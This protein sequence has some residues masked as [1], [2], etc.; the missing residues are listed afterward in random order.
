MALHPV[1]V[2]QLRQHLILPRS[3]DSLRRR[4][5]RGRIPWRL[6]PLRRYNKG[7]AEAAT[8]ERG[9]RRGKVRV[10]NSAA[11]RCTEVRSR[12]RNKREVGGGGEQK[13]GEK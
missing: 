8:M 13:V 6:P 1:D 11:R 2:T 7:D 4:R 5:W 9:A 3:V 10:R 12:R